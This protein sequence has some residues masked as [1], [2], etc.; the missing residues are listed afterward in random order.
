MVFFG[1]GRSFSPAWF[2]ARPYRVANSI[3]VVS[4]GTHLG[5]YVG[6][7]SGAQAKS[8]GTLYVCGCRL[9]GDEDSWTVH[10]GGT[11]ICLKGSIYEI[12]KQM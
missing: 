9:R 1:W 11:S 5:F 12:D 6:T 2:K 4:P 3:Q 8:G 10:I 7:E